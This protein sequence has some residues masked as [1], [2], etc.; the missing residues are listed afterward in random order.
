MNTVEQCCRAARW[1]FLSFVTGLQITSEEEYQAVLH[2][3]DRQKASNSQSPPLAREAD[4]LA[5]GTSPVP[6]PAHELPESSTT[7]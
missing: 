1:G 4:A 3:I 5:A 7:D 6:Y 2:L